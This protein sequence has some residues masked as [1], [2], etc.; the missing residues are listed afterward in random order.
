MLLKDK[1]QLSEQSLLRPRDDSQAGPSAVPPPSF[2][3]SAG[4]IVIDIN[5]IVDAFPTG[6]EEPPEFTPYEA[7]HW[8]S[9]NGE[10][11]SHDP[12]L[13]EDGEALYRFLLSQAETPPDFLIQCRG[14]HSET[15]TR[16]VDK[17]D[18]RGRRYTDTEHYTE[19]VTDFDFTIEYQVPPRATQWTVGDEEPAYRGHMSRE[20]GPPGETTKADRATRKAFESWLVKRNMRG[21]PPWVGSCSDRLEEHTDFQTGAVQQPRPTDVLKSSRTL[22]QWADDYCQSRKIFKEFVYEKVVYG[23][24]LKA[25]EAAIRATIASTHYR[26]DNVHVRFKSRYKTVIVRPDGRISRAI[27]NPWLKFLLIITLIYPFI[28]L[29]KR[30]HSRGG[31]SWAVGGGAYALKRWALLRDNAVPGTLA[32]IHDTV[33]GPRIL[34]GEREGQWFKRW[35]GTIR[36]SVVGRK[37]NKTP[38]QEPDDE[39]INWPATELDGF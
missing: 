26:G 34:V 33:E 30:F 15:H 21:L 39:V 35:E 12:H 16:L 25:L 24:D 17:T 38:M 2:E 31:G 22:R 10:I 4:H 3:E 18:S 29:F 37:V 11:I 8:V 28:W 13:N 6:G 14:T 20:V 5:G 7:E 36:R 27:S 23:W 32:E 9:K 1:D 19:N